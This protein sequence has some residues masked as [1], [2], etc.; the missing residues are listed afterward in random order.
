MAAYF[1]VEILEINDPGKYGRYIAG[2]K[3]IVEKNGGEYILRSDRTSPFFGEPCPV[4]VIFIKFSDKDRL[5]KCFNSDE[6][7]T[8]AP[9]REESTKARAFVIED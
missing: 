8:I 4:R 6:Y 3:D 1:L 5:E 7:R 9:L 2:V